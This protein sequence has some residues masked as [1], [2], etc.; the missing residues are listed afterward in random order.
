MTA[1]TAATLR[2]AVIGTGKMGEAIRALASAAH[3]TVVATIGENRNAGGRGITQESLAGAEVAIDFTEPGSAVS[4][5]SA[6]VAAGC[7][8]VVGTTGWYDQ[9]PAV[10][11]EVREKSGALLWAANFSIGVNILIELARHAGAMAA[12]SAAFDAHIIETHHTG[13]KDAPSGTAI[14]L[15]Q[16]ARDG[17]GKGIPITSVRTGS[18]PGTHEV[19][20]DGPFEQITL[21]HLARDRRVFAEGALGA[22]RWLRGKQGVFTMADM[23]RTA[24]DEK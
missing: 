3:C 5:I 20:F 17:F 16:A 13:K 22:A 2:I 19:V 12:R 9:L 15:E 10:S 23:L 1:T 8:I 7:P 24:G 14:V 11:A 6:C 18:V 21:S 4:N